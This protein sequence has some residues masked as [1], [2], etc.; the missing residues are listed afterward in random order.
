MPDQD[1]NAETP[2]LTYDLF[3]AIVCEGDNFSESNYFPLVKKRHKV[4]RKYQWYAFNQGLF[5]RIDRNEA[6][7]DYFP[8]LLFYRHNANGVSERD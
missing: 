1:P 3:G 5:T 4:S 8:Q 2:P 7:R 6:L